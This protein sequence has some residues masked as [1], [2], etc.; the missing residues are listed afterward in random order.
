MTIF[1]QNEKLKTGSQVLRLWPLKTFPF[2]VS[3]YG[4]SY[5]ED[6]DYPVFTIM[7]DLK[8][9]D[10]KYVYGRYMTEQNK[11]QIYKFQK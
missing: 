10:T 2:T 3:S 9:F 6:D 1:D 4:C 7:I 11:N 5:I 8:K